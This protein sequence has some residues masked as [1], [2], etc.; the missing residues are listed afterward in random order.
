MAAPKSSLSQQ[1]SPDMQYGLLE[2]I[3]KGSFGKVYKGINRTTNDIVAVKVI[4]LEEAE[5]EID[6]IQKEISVLSQLDCQHV[7]KY[8]ASYVQ[9]S[10]LWIVMEYLGGG[11]ILDML[12]MGPLEEIYIAVVLRE[13]LKGMDYLHNE[14]HIHR[15]IKAANILL[16][17]SGEVKLADFGVSGK[18]TNTMSK[19]NT[20]VGTPFWMAPEVIQQANYDAKADIWSI[21][22]TAYEMANR[23]PP[24]AEIH[25]MRVLF[26]IPKNE[27]PVLEG[28]F[29]KTFKDFVSECLKKDPND[30]PTAKELLRHR[31]IKQAKKSS[32][33]TDLIER[34]QRFLANNNNMAAASPGGLDG[35]TVKKMPGAEPG[36]D[37]GTVKK[38]GDNVTMDYSYFSVPTPEK[39]PASR[40]ISGDI[41][42]HV[43]SFPLLADVVFP[44]IDKLISAESDSSGRHVEGALTQAK[45]ALETA[46]AAKPGTTHKL[47]TEIFNSIVSNPDPTVA[48]MLPKV[49]GST[50]AGTPVVLGQDSENHETARKKN[51]VASEFLLSRWRDRCSASE[52]N[53]SVR[54][55]GSSS[56]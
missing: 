1:C 22:I 48:N 16:S 29:S 21:G 11:S 49:E 40:V 24:F 35:D 12:E 42:S 15:D 23:E 41:S 52:A 27:P 31:F 50:T 39:R 5:D 17:S 51:A 2:E 10:K 54:P 53:R 56:T 8:Y 38:S 37:F 9:G 55:H 46:E 45:K 32:I 4:D 44:V 18:L 47:L 28:N 13:I 14:R 26:L 3:G 30:R 36:W 20:F 19:R 43:L 34:R 33:L 7:T 6:D 25:P